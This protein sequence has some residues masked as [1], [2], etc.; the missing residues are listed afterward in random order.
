MKK[1]IA[2][3]IT[4][5]LAVGALA[6]CGSTPGDKSDAQTRATVE[7]AK[8]EEA[9]GDKVQYDPTQQV[10]NGEAVT[11]DLWQWG[12][13]AL[14]KQITDAYTKLQPN[15]TINIV[16][17]PWDDYWTK[18]PLALKGSNGPALF[19]IHNSQHANIIKYMEPYDIPVADMQADFTGVDAHII[20]DKV[21]YIDYGIMTGSVYYN[22]DMW[23]AAGLT[24]AD[25]P[26]TWDEFR[27]VAKKLT[28]LEGDSV[29]Q[30]GINFNDEINSNYLM[31]LNYQLGDNLFDKDMT[32]IKV[33]T[34]NMKKVMQMMFDIYEVDKSG[35]KDF[36]AK[37]NESFGQGQSAMTIQWGWY[38]NTLNNDY[39]DIKFGV[40]EIP[41]FDG[42]PY[43]YNRYNGESTFGINKNIPA[44]Q[45][46][47]AQDFVKFFLAYDGGQK[48]FNLEFSTFPAKK[49]LANDSDI[50]ANPAM[51]AVSAHIDK[52]IW[53][54]PMPAI[55][56]DTLKIAAQDIMF[57]GKDIGTAF[58]EAEKTI[59]QGLKSAGFVSVENLYK[60]AK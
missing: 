46:A 7:G 21:Y 15:V 1:I 17:N 22:K 23:E 4:G 14:F 2:L 24:E 40:F 54:G 13:E 38:N 50:L 3:V 37:G 45:M 52:Y 32:S 8:E 28:I 11:I 25:I 43:A 51:A 56:E 60:Y 33:N 48:L 20:D 12:E 18:L 35:S 29:V 39:S 30:A 42:D 9:F 44:D 10:N 5:V 55:I 27:A 49:S 53:P 47:V 41:T 34:D 58:S 31:G 36:G 6:G 19:N 57:N 59:N 26:K 16:N